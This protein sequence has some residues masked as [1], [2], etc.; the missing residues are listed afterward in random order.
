MEALA[1]YIFIIIAG[2]STLLLLFTKNV[3]HAAYLLM[4]T[5][6]SVAGI[7]I[8]LNA[9][10]IG[11]AQLMVYVGGILILLIFGIMLTNRLTG[12]HIV[13]GTHNTFKGV[14]IGMVLMTAL[15]SLI[16]VHHFIPLDNRATTPGQIS[17]LGQQLMTDYIFEFEII[18]ILLLLVLIGAAFI[19]KH[20]HK[21]IDNGYPE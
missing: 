13:S 2:L 9:E 20:S 11:V 12:Q 14:I 19:A 18:G 7:F 16:Y 1:T 21:S 3:L 10:F 5:L 6:L 4:A 15:C 8:L 17:E